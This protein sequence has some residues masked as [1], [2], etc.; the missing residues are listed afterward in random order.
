[1]RVHKPPFSTSR[2]RTDSVEKIPDPTKLF[3][4]TES[5]LQ[6]SLLGATG[7]L[8]VGMIYWVIL[9]GSMIVSWLVGQRLKSKFAQYSQEPFPLSGRE[10][11]EKMLREQGIT[12]VKVISTPGRLTDHYNPADRTVNLSESVYNLRN[13]AAAAV[14]AHECGHAVQHAKSYAWLG[15][16]SKMV[17]VVGVASKMMGMIAMISILGAGFFGNPWMM[18]LFVGALAITTLFAFVTLPVE[19]DASK[20]ALAWINESG[21][22]SSMGQNKAK[23]ALF[24]A[25][26]TYVVAALASLAQL[27]Y[28]L[29]LMFGRRD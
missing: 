4:M 25:A 12:G 18:S 26:M 17:P 2:K 24:W 19:F 21:L 7:F 9:G 1:M 23:D 15:M 11:A 14:S 22:T 27:L 8:G 29:Y 10:V 3:R 13:V 16:R 6:I 28:Y 20:R 5:L